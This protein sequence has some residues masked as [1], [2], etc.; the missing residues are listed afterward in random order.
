MKNLRD[1][2]TT[3]I[4]LCMDNKKVREDSEGERLSFCTGFSSLTTVGCLLEII[5]ML[6]IPSLVRIYLALGA[7]TGN[8]SQSLIDTSSL[9]GYD[10]SQT[11]SLASVQ[12][13]G[14]PEQRTLLQTKS[15]LKRQK[16]SL[17]KVKGAYA[18]KRANGHSALTRAFLQPV[19]TTARHSH[20]TVTQRGAPTHLPSSHPFY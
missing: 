1:E 15:R 14:P 8:L 10:H 16:W 13:S 6:W 7:S 18:R 4:A 5:T 12:Y 19:G 11:Q 9:G 3:H 17:Y 20:S 2:K